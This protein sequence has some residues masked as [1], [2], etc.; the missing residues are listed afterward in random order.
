VT[1]W[2]WIDPM[3]M[4]GLVCVIVA[5]IIA[6]FTWDTGGKLGAVATAICAFLLIPILVAVLG[7]VACCFHHIFWT[8]WHPYF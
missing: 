6:L 5:G 1:L 4:T 8:I 2:W 7:G 3:A